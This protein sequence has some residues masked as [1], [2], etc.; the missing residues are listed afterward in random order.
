MVYKYILVRPFQSEDRNDNY[1]SRQHRTSRSCSGVVYVTVITAM[2]FNKNEGAIIT[3]TE[4]STVIRK[5][6]HVKKISGFTITGAVGQYAALVGGTGDLALIDETITNARRD[7]NQEREHLGSVEDFLSLFAES[8]NATWREHLDAHIYSKLGVRMQDFLTGRFSTIRTG[9]CGPKGEEAQLAPYILNH[10]FGIVEGE[11]PAAAELPSSSYIM[12]TVD[13][14][15][16]GIHRADSNYCKPWRMSAI[17]Y[18]C[19]GSG[20][21]L[22]DATLADYVDKLGRDHL[23][24]IDPLTGLNMLIW[25]TMRASN[26]NSGVGGVPQ[27]G[28]IKENKIY[29]P[30]QERC[31]LASDIVRAGMN[32]FLPHEFHL[33]ALERTLYDP[34]AN[35]VRIYEDMKKKSM[36]KNLD[37]HLHGYLK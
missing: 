16:I 14:I 22:A 28:I 1:L 5:Y 26:R 15:N 6:K 13:Q 23:D 4:A 25:A 27:I 37:A 11:S 24:D 31:K 33:H 9:A 8:A 10:I 21:D 35:P 36:R 18:A 7:V 3:D 30:E 32:G 20:A 19:A 12:L 17:P 2:R 34:K 29:D